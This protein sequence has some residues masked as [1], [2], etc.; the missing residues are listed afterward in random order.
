MLRPMTAVQSAFVD[1]CIADAKYHILS[2]MEVTVIGYEARCYNDL[3]GNIVVGKY[4]F[5]EHQVT[6]G[7]ELFPDAPGQPEGSGFDEVYYDIIC[8]AL[9][10][11]LSGP[12]IPLDQIQSPPELGYD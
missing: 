3:A 11:W 12:V 10:E 6:L 4:G 1:M 2:L 8:T 9:D 5:C 7:R